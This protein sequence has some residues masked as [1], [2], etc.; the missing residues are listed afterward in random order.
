MSSTTPSSHWNKTL[1]TE[2]FQHTPSSENNNNNNNNNNI[3][4]T[5]A[6]PYFL[7]FNSSSFNI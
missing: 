7:S 1:Q 5:Q 6:P 4:Y 2:P 3:R